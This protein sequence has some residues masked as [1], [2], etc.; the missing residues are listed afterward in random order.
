MKWI[1]RILVLGVCLFG[2]GAFLAFVSSKIENKNF[3]ES[4]V[5]NNRVKYQRDIENVNKLIIKA[6]IGKINLKPNNQDKITYIYQGLFANAF[7]SEVV[8]DVLLLNSSNINLIS[9]TSIENVTLDVLIP[10]E[11][12]IDI[13]IENS[14]ANVEAD[15]IKVN[16]LSVGSEVG[17]IKIEN[18]IVN[19]NLEAF[20]RVGTIKIN[21]VKE[22]ENIDIQNSVGLIELS[23]LYGKNV[24]LKNDVGSINYINSNKNYSFKSLEVDVSV[25]KQIIKVK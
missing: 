23:D 2:I 11:T 21:N 4:I 14:G 18:T 25:G 8:D 6:D 17:L 9:F 5:I 24:Y 22:P 19:D 12:K 13:I 10:N 15:G 20:N 7:K 3:F 16:T 1:K